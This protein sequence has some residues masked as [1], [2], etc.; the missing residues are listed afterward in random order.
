MNGEGRNGL[1]AMS[2]NAALNHRPTADNVA[3][4][5]L[6][7]LFPKTGQEMPPFADALKDGEIAELTNYVFAT[8]GNPEIRITQHRVTELRNG[9]VTSPLLKLVRLAAG[10]AAI[11]VCLLLVIVIRRLTKRARDN[12]SLSKQS[13]G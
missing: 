6:A 5:V 3:M 10:A 1:P 11:I 2:G 8:F 13:Q 9:G 12:E 4:A 7:G